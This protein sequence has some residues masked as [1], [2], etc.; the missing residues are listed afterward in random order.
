MLGLDQ[1]SLPWN[2]VPAAQIAADRRLF[3]V[4]LTRVRDA[5]HLLYSGWIKTR[6]GRPWALGRSVLVDE[7][8]TELIKADLEEARAH[9]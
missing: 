5:V 6:S 1:G 8:Q 9:R 7:L 4:E 2:N 3:Y